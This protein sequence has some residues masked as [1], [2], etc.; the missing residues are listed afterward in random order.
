MHCGTV[1]EILSHLQTSFSSF[2][3]SKAGCFKQS[4]V[5]CLLDQQLLLAER[6]AGQL[7][8]C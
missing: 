3:N 1:T 8:L 6:L 2:D 5:S 7:S 4:A